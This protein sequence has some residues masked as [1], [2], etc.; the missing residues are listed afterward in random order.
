MPKPHELE[1]RIEQLKALNSELNRETQQRKEELS[2]LRE[3]LSNKSAQL[4][5]KK[6]QYNEMLQSVENFKSDY[7]E[8][9][10]QPNQI[11]KECDKIQI[12]IELVFFLLIR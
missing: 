2:D 10:T 9:N 7:V 12:E 1:R 5:A 4:D 3:L 8:V 6:K 11:M